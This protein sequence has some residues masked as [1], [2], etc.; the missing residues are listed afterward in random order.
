[1]NVCD[2][3]NQLII[4]STVKIVYLVIKKQYPI[5]KANDKNGCFSIGKVLVKSFFQGR[6]NF[7]FKSSTKLAIG[8][9]KALFCS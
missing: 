7:S 2:T 8:E 6:Y 9:L 3:A 4:E 5:I 1:M